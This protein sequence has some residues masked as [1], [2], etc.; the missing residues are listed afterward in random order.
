MIH[1]TPIIVL[2]LSMTVPLGIAVL[3]FAMTRRWR[4]RDGRRSPLAERLYHG[5]GEQLRVRISHHD[6]EIVA[7]L[8]VV[9]LIGPLTLA[10]WGVNH[11]DWSDART[12]WSLLVPALFA[13]LFVFWASRKILHHTQE[14]Q[15]AREGLAAELM[16]A[17]QLLPLMASGCQIFHDIPA[18]N[19]N[20]DHVVIG[21]YAVYLI[22]TKSRKK[23]K[24]QG[25]DSARV[26]YDGERL[27]FPDHIT[28]KP[29]EQVRSEAQWL[30]DHLRSAAG[31]AVRIVPV[32]ALPG[33]YVVNGKDANRSDVSVI[34][35]KMHTI[36]FD[37]RHGPPISDS[38]RNRIAHALVQQYP[39]LS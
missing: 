18:K 28:A 32:V 33:W 26:T 35:P 15:F 13:L 17:Q 22:E 16:T 27:Q 30:H 37:K 11:A 31:E 10:A 23:P 2:L 9:F 7:A 39:E 36:F 6:E 1:M 20:L 5:P 34:N 29:I 3:V 21:P 25:K 12:A 14:R 38:L 24:E 8:L 19:F 4:A